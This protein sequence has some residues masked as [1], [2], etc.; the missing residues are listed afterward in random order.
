MLILGVSAAQKL[1]QVAGS[2]PTYPHPLDACPGHL[3]AVVQLQALQATAVLQVLQGHVGDEEA[4]VQLQHLQPLVAAGAVAQVQDSVVRD[5]LTVGQAL[6][7]GG[8]MQDLIPPLTAGESREQPF[9][10]EVRALR[11]WDCC[12]GGGGVLSLS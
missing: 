3:L 4:V 11:P 5:E 1:C 9:A 12:N 2:C 8:D 10:Y 7:Q 6:Q